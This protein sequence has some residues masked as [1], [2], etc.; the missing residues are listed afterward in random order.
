M[1]NNTKRNR[2]NE[3]KIQ[4]RDDWQNSRRLTRRYSAANDFSEGLLY[5]EQGLPPRSMDA[6]L[7]RK[8]DLVARE[9]FFPL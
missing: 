7:E 5:V 8:I 6:I 4:N 9:A 1:Q 2:K 3:P